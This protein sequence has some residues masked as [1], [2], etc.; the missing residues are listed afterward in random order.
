MLVAS[1]ITNMMKVT[2]NLAAFDVGWK[3]ESKVTDCARG[4]PE[5]MSQEVGAFHRVPRVL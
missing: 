3:T 2:R 4:T 5:R 1:M